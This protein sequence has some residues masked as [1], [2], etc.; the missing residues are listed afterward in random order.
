MRDDSLRLKDIAEAIARIERYSHQGREALDRDELIQTWYVHHIQIIGEAVRLLSDQTRQLRP[1]IPWNQIV[2]MRHILVHQYFGIDLNEIWNVIEK[3]LPALKS[4]VN[5]LISKAEP[6][7]G[8][9]PATEAK[10]STG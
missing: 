10:H 5:D 8:D 4:A 1:E 2:G 6:A 3:H 9:D 7:V